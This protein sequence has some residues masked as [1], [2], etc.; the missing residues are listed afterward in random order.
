[1]CEKP[2][3]FFAFFRRFVTLHNN[4]YLKLLIPFRTSAENFCIAFH[5]FATTPYAE[6]SQNR[7]T[8]CAD[9]KCSD[10]LLS[11]ASAPRRTD[12]SACIGNRCSL[13]RKDVKSPKY[14][15]MGEILLETTESVITPQMEQQMIYEA[16]LRGASAVII[17]EMDARFASPPGPEVIIR[18][19]R[20]RLVRYQ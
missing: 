2:A 19:V 14:E 7:F 15:F 3:F 1:M 16:R 20:A 11:C 13:C 6:T 4:E 9:C 17:G 10:K 12:V 5:Y 8:S 18:T